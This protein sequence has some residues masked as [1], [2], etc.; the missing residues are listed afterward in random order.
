VSQENGERVQRLYEYLNQGDIDAAL[1]LLDPGVEWWTREDTPATEIAKGREGW[2]ARWG[3]ITG[4]LEEFHQEP[5]EVID[6]GEYVVV[7]VHQ[8]ARA[9]GVL[10]DQDEV[11]V[12]RLRDG[13][14]IE[15]REFREKR[16]AL[17]AIGREG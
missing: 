14:V 2:R 10:I 6:A 5:T 16:E 3:D 8:V 17:E 13:P 12:F 15:L 9:Q 4:V 11:H 1:A 7:C